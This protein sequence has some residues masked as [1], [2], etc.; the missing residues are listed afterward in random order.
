MR[1]TD[2]LIENLVLPSNNLI[3][4][5]LEFQKFLEFQEFFEFL[6]FHEFR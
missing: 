4:E 3:L 5:Y 6:E 2:Q 1:L